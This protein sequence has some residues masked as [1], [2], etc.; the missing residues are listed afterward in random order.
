[1]EDEKIKLLKREIRLAAA[2]ARD[3]LPERERALYSREIEELLFAHEPFAGAR[4]VMI[5][6]SFRSE[7]ETGGIIR[8]ALDEG[9]KVLVPVVS[10][11]RLAVSE[12]R[13]PEVELA[14]GA[15]GIPEPR[16]EC[17]RIVDPKEIDFTAAPGLAFDRCGGRIGYGGGYYDRFARE[18]RAGTPV[19]GLAFS[20]Q[21]FDAI[22][23]E[24]NDM[25]VSAI[26]TEKEIIVPT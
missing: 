10:G 20:A 13:D 8:R 23:M 25:R 15:Y 7:V 1:M 5:F 3:A 16:K 12:V 4:T 9:K 17:L 19:V 2:A 22:P 14:A 6:V 11:G 18:L 21:I 24:K 26:V